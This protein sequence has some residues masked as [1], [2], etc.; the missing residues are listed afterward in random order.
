MKSKARKKLPKYPGFFF[1]IEPG[2]LNAYRKSA[3]SAGLTLSE[4]I[5]FHCDAALR[6]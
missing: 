2:K 3:K 6:K 1:R 5:R 4:W